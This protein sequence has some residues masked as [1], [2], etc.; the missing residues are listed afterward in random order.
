MREKGPLIHCWCECRLVQLL[1][2]TI[3]KLL[4][5]LNIGLPYNPAIPLLRI[6][7]KECESGYNK[8]T[9]TPMFIAVLF[10]LRYGNNQD[11]PLLMG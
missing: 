10:T 2:K 6:Y 1:W 4:K 5:K 11:I 8:G 9:Y 3:W 7:Q